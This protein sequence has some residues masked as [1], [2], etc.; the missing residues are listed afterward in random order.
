MLSRESCLSR[1]V[2]VCWLLILIWRCSITRQISTTLDVAIKR[3]VQ[4][5]LSRSSGLS[6]PPLISFPSRPHA[7]IVFKTISGSHTPPQSGVPGS[8]PKRSVRRV[9]IMR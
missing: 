7:L 4:S 5:V 9:F 1:M 3:Y 6:P 2:A 8:D